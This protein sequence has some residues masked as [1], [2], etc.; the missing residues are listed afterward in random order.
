MMIHQYMYPKVT[1]VRPGAGGAAKPGQ[2]APGGSRRG[3]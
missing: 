1:P 3:R 2:A